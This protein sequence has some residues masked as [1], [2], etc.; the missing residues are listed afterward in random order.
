MGK[1][2]DSHLFLHNCFDHYCPFFIYRQ[3]SVLRKL[4]KSILDK[5]NRNSGNS[6][7]YVTTHYGVYF[8]LGLNP[9][10]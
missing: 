4:P 1:K 3:N 6:L 10:S 5:R 8:H 9:L 2:R 7:I